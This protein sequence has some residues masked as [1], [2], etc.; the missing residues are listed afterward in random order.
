LEG[1]LSDLTPTLFE[2]KASQVFKNAMVI[3]FEFAINIRWKPIPIP[4]QTPAGFASKKDGKRPKI[5]PY[6]QLS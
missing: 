2:F 4:L 5:Y 6:D 1:I 3:V